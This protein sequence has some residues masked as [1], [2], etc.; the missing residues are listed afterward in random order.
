MN[1]LAGN[2]DTSGTTSATTA[3]KATTAGGIGRKSSLSFRR[4]PGVDPDTGEVIRPKSEAK[5]VGA[6]AMFV[7]RTRKAAV[8]TSTDK[9]VLL[10]LKLKK[11]KKKIATA[12]APAAPAESKGAENGEN[13][14]GGL[15]SLNLQHKNTLAPLRK[16]TPR[17]KE[18]GASKLGVVALPIA[19]TTTTTTTIITTTNTTTTAGDSKSSATPSEEKHDDWDSSRHS[20]VASSAADDDNTGKISRARSRKS[21]FAELFAKLQKDL[22][23]LKTDSRQAADHSK[24]VGEHLDKWESSNRVEKKQ[25]RS[26]L[27]RLSSLTSRRSSE[28]VDVHARTS[29][30]SAP[31]IASTS[32]G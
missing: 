5:R 10:K 12:A 23:D 16:L 19:T 28:L 17:Q 15:G 29:S 30:A 14:R 2:A 13:P 31:N 4:V 20:S 9:A 7:H 24:N 22:R 1:P 6:A 3:K 11:K 8:K 26:F 21:I 18:L 27:Q 25:R 32:G